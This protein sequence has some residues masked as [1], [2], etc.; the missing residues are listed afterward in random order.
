MFWPTACTLN[1]GLMG[2][3]LNKWYKFIA[4]LFLIMVVLQVFFIAL[5]V[6]IY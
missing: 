3:P 4:P 2:V 1:C 6:Y 5:S